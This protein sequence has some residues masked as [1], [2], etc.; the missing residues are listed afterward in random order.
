MVVA[1]TRRTFRQGDPLP[2]V[3]ALHFFL[4]VISELL[5]SPCEP[6]YAR[7]LEQKLGP[8]AALK[9]AEREAAPRQPQNVKDR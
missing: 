3:R 2:R 8:L 5:E 6:G 1:V 9:A 7:Y 4:P